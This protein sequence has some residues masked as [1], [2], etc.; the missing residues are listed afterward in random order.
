MPIIDKT[1]GHTDEKEYQNLMAMTADGAIKGYLY[2]S[3]TY[4]AGSLA[5]GAGVTT[6]I[7]VNGAALGDI[8]R[9]SLGVDLAGITLSSYVSA[10]NI[11]SV[12]LQNESGGT[13][14]LASTTLRALVTD[15][16]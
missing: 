16:T 13:L 6:T 1:Y 3:A 15:L 7:T 8:A 5:D 9:V 10:A 11:V 2:N 14:D 4:D 12:R